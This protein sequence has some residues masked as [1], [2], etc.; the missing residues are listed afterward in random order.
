MSAGSVAKSDARRA[1]VNKSAVI[2]V[3]AVKV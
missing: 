1:L 3:R 2:A